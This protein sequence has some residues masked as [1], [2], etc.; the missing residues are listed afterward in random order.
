M[1]NPFGWRD[2]P[3]LNYFF[4]LNFIEKYNT[5]LL[6]R[7]LLKRIMKILLNH[8]KGFDVTKTEISIEFCS[9]H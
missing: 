4:V 9:F 2:F 6:F 5:N 3:G 7:R 8:R 1:D